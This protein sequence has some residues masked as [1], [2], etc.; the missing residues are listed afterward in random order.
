MQCRATLLEASFI[1]STIC[2][3]VCGT[4]TTCRASRSSSV[5]RSHVS[6]RDVFT[7][8][9][10]STARCEPAGLDSHWA[11]RALGLPTSHASKSLLLPAGG[12]LL[13]C[14]SCRSALFTS[15]KSAFLLHQLLVYSFR[16]S[17][18]QPPI[19]VDVYWAARPRLTAASRSCC[20]TF[21]SHTTL[22]DRFLLVRSSW[23]FASR[24]PW[25]S[26]AATM[27]FTTLRGKRVRFLRLS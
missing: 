23:H 27:N 3:W 7:L 12:P 16:S 8:V 26:I 18:H 9:L 10:S 21:C 20:P 14:T 25:H 15:W 11:S 19:F 22:L 17:Y 6:H 4:Q 13:S 5:P 1:T 2:S 24:P